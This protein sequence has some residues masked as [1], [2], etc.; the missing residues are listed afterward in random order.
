ML[1]GVWTESSAKMKEGWLSDEAC[2]EGKSIPGVP[3][4]LRGREKLKFGLGKTDDSDP[5]EGD[6]RK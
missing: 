4:L 5:T 6:L 1:T 3:A 2:L